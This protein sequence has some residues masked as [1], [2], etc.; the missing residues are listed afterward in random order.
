MASIKSL[1]VEV[2]GT[3]G[4]QRLERQARGYHRHRVALLNESV[5]NPDR[6]LEVTDLP[7]GFATV[8][9]AFQRGS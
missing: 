2:K 4:W 5:T 8:G 3:I 7:Q 6:V 9:K 1:E